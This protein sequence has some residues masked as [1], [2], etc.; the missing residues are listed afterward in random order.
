MQGDGSLFVYTSSAG[1]WASN[2]PSD[3]AAY[4]LME[5]DG[6][7]VI[8]TITGA[9]LWASNTGGNPGA[10]AYLLDTGKLVVKNTAGTVIWTT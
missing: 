6:N 2:S 1:I 9:A 4:V 5:S 7:L 10:T 3:Q 8:R